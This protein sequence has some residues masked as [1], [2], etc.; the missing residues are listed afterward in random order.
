MGTVTREDE[1]YIE[2]GP[3]RLRDLI[4][5]NAQIING[6]LQANVSTSDGFVGAISF[7]PGETYMI[8]QVNKITH[9]DKNG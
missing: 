8:L 4:V 2:I 6:S 7:T 5:E 1:M 3:V 9:E